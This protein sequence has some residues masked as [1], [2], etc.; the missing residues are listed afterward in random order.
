MDWKQMQVRGL[1][2]R[3]AYVEK[4]R[5]IKIMTRENIG[6]KTVGNERNIMIMNTTRRRNSLG[7]GKNILVF[8]DDTLEVEMLHRCLNCLNRMELGNNAR[9]TLFEEI[10]HSMG[11]DDLRGACCDSLEF[12]LLFLLLELHG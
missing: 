3:Y 12:I 5:V 7:S 9:M 1:N 2:V 4:F 6:M 8:E 10:F 11:T